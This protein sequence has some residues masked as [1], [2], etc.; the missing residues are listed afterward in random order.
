M[1]TT[2]AV[3]EAEVVTTLGEA[4]EATERLILENQTLPVT[5]QGVEAT[6]VIPREDIRPEVL[7]RRTPPEA[8]VTEDQA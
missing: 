4:A 7:A 2:T 3:A 6:I 1:A 8:E 5:R